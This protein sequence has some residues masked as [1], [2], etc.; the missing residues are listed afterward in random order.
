MLGLSVGLCVWKRRGACG[1]CGGTDIFG[2]WSIER[3]GEWCSGHGRSGQVRT[4]ARCDGC[5]GTSG[6]SDGFGGT[7]ICGGWCGASRGAH[8]RE[9]AFP[10]E[11]FSIGDADLDGISAF[12]VRGTRDHHKEVGFVE[13][14]GVDFDGVDRD[15][16]AQG[17]I[18]G[19]KDFDAVALFGRGAV[20][21]TDMK[22]VADGSVAEELI[23]FAASA[24]KGGLGTGSAGA[25]HGECENRK[26]Q[27]DQGRIDQGAGSFEAEAGTTFEFGLRSITD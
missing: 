7:D 15:D 5:S 14:V 10:C 11:V 18:F 20:G 25:G 12:V 26:E 19:A 21:D 4:G 9:A 3:T 22:V 1:C 2:G 6:W 24:Q 23:R 27:E 17:A 16:G 13:S 8:Q